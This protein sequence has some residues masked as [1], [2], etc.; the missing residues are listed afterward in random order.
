[1]KVFISSTYVDLVEHR[2]AVADALERLGLQLS[3][4]ETFGAQ[5]VDATKACFD[6]IEES[7]LFVGIYAHRY[8]YVPGSAEKSITELEFDYA[9]KLLRPTFCFILDRTYPWPPHLVDKGIQSEKLSMFIQRIENLV[10]RDVFTTPDVLAGRVAS[11]VGRFLIS[12]PRKHGARSAADY[13]RLTLADLAPAVFVDLMRLTGYAGSEEVRKANAGRHLE[14][15]DIADQHLSEF[16]HQTTRL[17]YDSDFHLMEAANGVERALGLLLTRLRRDGGH[18]PSWAEFLGLLHHAAERVEALITQ[19]SREYV[20]KRRAEVSDAIGAVTKDVDA[21]T[22]TTL[23]VTLV[24]LRH[25]A[26]SKVISQ[27]QRTG[28]FTI[29]TVRDDV[30][31][32]LAIPYFTIDLMLLRKAIEVSR[33]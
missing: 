14:F 12:D 5:P 9:S 16:K 29:A 3:R 20:E 10:V 32:Q 11:S 23:P 30:D 2:R 18:N 27:M 17:S 6:A 28:G 8:G 33:I 13:A 24:R 4:M 1:M 31:R 21:Q 22:L 19:V 26:Q 25:A 15:V 7:E